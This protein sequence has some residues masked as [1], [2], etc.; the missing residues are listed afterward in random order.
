MSHFRP[1]DIHAGLCDVAGGDVLHWRA[2][3]HQVEGDV[4]DDQ[5]IVA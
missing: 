4:V 3:R 5:S 2:E 1:A